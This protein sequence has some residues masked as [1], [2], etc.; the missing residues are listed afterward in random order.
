MR[1]LKEKLH[2]V[3]GY[4]DKR[5][6]NID[7][8][9]AFIVDDRSD[10]DINSRGQLYPYFCSILVMP[11]SE[12]QV[13]VILSGNI[14]QNDNLKIW[15]QQNNLELKQRG[16]HENEHDLNIVITP[17]NPEILNQL[18]KQFEKIIEPGKRYKINNY[19]YVCP[20]NAN[21]LRRLA[22]TLRTHWD[23]PSTPMPPH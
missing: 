20:R 4:N 6:K 19:K 14:P 13:N 16:P 15:L 23:S 3:Y 7:K 18:A 21:S 17:S 8:M 10:R 22:D 5:V 11:K 12:N 1:Q 9:R 2:K